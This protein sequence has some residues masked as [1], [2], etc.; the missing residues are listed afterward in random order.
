MATKPVKVIWFLPIIS[1][2]W[3]LKQRIAMKESQLDVR[4]EL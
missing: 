3:R 2:A 1:A 4:S